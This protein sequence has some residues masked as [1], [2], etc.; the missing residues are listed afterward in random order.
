[1]GK[2][3]RSSDDFLGTGL[4]ARDNCFSGVSVAHFHDPVRISPLQ[5]TL[6]GAFRRRIDG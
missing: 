2:G 6:P 1:M 5:V 4:F 3:T